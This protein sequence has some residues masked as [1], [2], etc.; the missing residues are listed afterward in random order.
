M[1]CILYK[2]DGR[3]VI[4]ELK[5]ESE[6]KDTRSVLKDQKYT[7]KIV[8]LSNILLHIIYI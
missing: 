3:N 8:L 2:G 7:L 5:A 6:W 1:E 4:Y